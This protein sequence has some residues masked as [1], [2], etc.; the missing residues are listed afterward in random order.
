MRRIVRALFVLALLGGL[1]AAVPPGASA[2]G[3]CPT[4]QVEVRGRVTDAATGLPL[5]EVTSVGVVGLDT[6]YNDGWGTNAASRFTGCLDPGSYAIAFGADS[7][8]VEWYHN[9]T[10]ATATP[11]EVALPG[12]VI[13]NEAL[14]P[15][16]LVLAGRITNR[17]GRGVPAS[18]GIFRQ[19]PNGTWASIDGEGNDGDTGIWSYRVPG[20]GRYRVNASV[21]HHWSR[22]HRDATRLRH[23][24]VLVVNATRTYVPNVNIAVP[25]CPGSV[26]GAFCVPSGFLT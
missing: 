2:G 4:G 25:Y 16:G 26:G 9:A 3:P 18:I 14:V 22:W 23:A 13:V 15:R 19:R 1:A 20:P 11:I 24:R 21:D 17:S 7:Y 6:T 12:P 10:Q 8:R 5:S